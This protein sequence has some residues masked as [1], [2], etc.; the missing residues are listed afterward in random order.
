MKARISVVV[1]MYNVA[2]YLQTCLE[3]LAQQTMADLEVVMVD[4]G[5]TDESPVIAERFAARDSRFRLVRQANAGLGAARNTGVVHAV[6]AFIAFVDSDDVVPRHA[7]ELLVGALDRTGSDMAAGNVRR[8]TQLGTVQVGFLARAFERPRLQTH[9]TRFPLLLA[10]R[11]AWNK[12]FRRSFWDQHGFRFPQ[13]VYHEDIPVTL[14]AHYL[15]RAVDLIDET[16]YLWRL[17]E[18]GE[19]SITQ[20]RTETKTLRDRVAAVDY[21][22][23]F[24]AD[25][26][27]PVSKALYDRTVVA[28]DLRYSLDLL[29]SAD[30]EYRRLF[31]DLANE[32]IDR[33]DP[34]ALEQRL[35]IDR[36]KWQLVRRRA[37]PELLEVLGFADEELAERPPVRKGRHWYGDYPYRM[38]ERLAIPPR[39]YRLNDEL[40]PVFRLND[41]RWEGDTLR[42]AF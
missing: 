10:D 42:I 31:I 13:G 38:D 6:G 32:F 36:L 4:D 40:A 7:Y 39:V 41:V 19:L 16:V 23:R 27:L 11:M 14:P 3:S 25:Q 21:V 5:S 37:L 9:I 8:L 33:A 34:W 12:V 22:S 28:Q 20:R 29:A 24:L 1:P 35:A 18:G 30:D 2:P 15:A 26:R 17:R